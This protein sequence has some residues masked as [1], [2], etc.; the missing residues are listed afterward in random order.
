MG[1]VLSVLL[2]LPPGLASAEEAFQLPS[3]SIHCAVHGGLLRCD[4]LS[5]AYRRPPRPPEWGG[6][7]R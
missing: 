6:A 7:R 4:T 1:R 5:F 3:G 2:L